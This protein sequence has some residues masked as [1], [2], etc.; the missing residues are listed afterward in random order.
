MDFDEYNET[1]QRE[2]G[3][4][5]QPENHPAED[6]QPPSFMPYTQSQER[7]YR[8]EGV[9]RRES[10]VGGSSYS[11]AAEPKAEPVGGSGKPWNYPESETIPTGEVI[12]PAKPPKSSGGK[13]TWLNILISA[14]ASAVV[15]AV[16]CGVVIASLNAYWKEQNDLLSQSYEE[17]LNLAKSE[18]QSSIDQNKSNTVQQPSQTTPDTAVPEVQSPVQTTPDTYM[19]PAQVY[20]QCVNSVVAINCTG[21]T[22]SYGQSMQTSSSGSGFI[23]SEDGYVATNYHVVEGQTKLEVSTYDGTTYDATYIG[24]NEAN[25]IALIK[26]DAQG[27]TPVTVG[28]SAD[29]VVGEQVAAIGNPLGELA[30]TLTVGYISAKDRIVATDGTQINMLQTD[31]AINPGNSGGP[32]FNMK[33][34][35]IGITSAKYSGTTTSGATI[36]GIGF[37]IPMDDVLGMLNDLREYGYITG[38]YLGISVSD[39]DEDAAELYGLPNGVLVREVTE[40]SCAEKAGIKV[41]DIIVN[42]GGYEVGNLNDLSRALNKFKAGETVT[43]TVYR[44]GSEKILSV[45]LDERPRE[46]SDSAADTQ[47]TTP[48]QPSVDGSIED[49]FDFFIP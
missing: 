3:E 32:L 39:V 15:A 28:V 44:S 9:G 35:V 40:G 27:L 41:Q 36:E 12:S 24:G 17:K 48:T 4:N 42:L 22:T 46:Q 38:G 26:V 7:L 31:A 23:L 30:S 1:P 43:V 11:S 14:A 5:V 20:A 47:P 16:I 29:L 33:G 13:K 10:T 18:L 6:A 45:T 25:D 37:A 2:T 49:W 8:G 21:T 19:T 34:E